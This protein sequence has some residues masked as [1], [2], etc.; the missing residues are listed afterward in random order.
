MIEKHPEG[1]FHPSLVL[2]MYHIFGITMFLWTWKHNTIVFFRL[3]YDGSAF[4][5]FE[6]SMC[7][8]LN[9]VTR[10]ASDGNACKH[11]QKHLL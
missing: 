5:F 4:A 1:C 7:C 3:Y 8:I 2:E 9:V 10:G 11:H 6:A